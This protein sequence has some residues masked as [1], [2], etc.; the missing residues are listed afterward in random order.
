MTVN[1][2]PI[3]STG[4]QMAGS[5]YAGFSAAGML[6]GATSGTHARHQH[7]GHLATGNGRLIERFQIEC[8]RSH[9]MWPAGMMADVAVSDVRKKMAVIKHNSRPVAGRDPKG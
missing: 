1:R 9:A 3:T 8:V 6:S 7:F 5:T 2:N 4:Q